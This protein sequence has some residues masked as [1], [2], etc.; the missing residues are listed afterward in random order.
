MLLENLNCSAISE[1]GDIT[2][3]GSMIQKSLVQLRWGEI[4]AQNCTSCTLSPD[5]CDMTYLKHPTS[6]GTHLGTWC[7]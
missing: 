7:H 2:H 3:P 4:A 5:H 1:P 6:S